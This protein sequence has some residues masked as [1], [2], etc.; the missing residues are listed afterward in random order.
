MD[1][2]TKIALHDLK[3]ITEKIKDMMLEYELERQDLIQHLAQLQVKVEALEEEN[4]QLLAD[5]QDLASQLADKIPT[6]GAGK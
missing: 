5:N 4:L 2:A 1:T 6:Q 3:A